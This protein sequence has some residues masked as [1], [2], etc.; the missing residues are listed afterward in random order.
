[1]NCVKEKLL[2]TDKGTVC[3]WQTNHWDA[4]LET[5][6]FLH[7]LTADHSMFEEQIA[8]FKKEYNVLAWDAP[9]HGRSRPF[10][11]FGFDDASAYKKI[12][13]M[14]ALSVKLFLW[15]SLWEDILPN[16]L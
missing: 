11:S 10:E 5:L 1:M 9:A 3:Y 14:N 2:R 15:G 6:F 8:C 7:G 13:W 12:S 4:R 16:P